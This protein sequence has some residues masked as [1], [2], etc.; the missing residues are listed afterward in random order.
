MLNTDI[1]GA[2]LVLQSPREP[3]L[4]LTLRRKTRTWPARG[5][6]STTSTTSLPPANRQHRIKRTKPSALLCH[7]T[8]KSCHVSTRTSFAGPGRATIPTPNIT[9]D[10]TL[11]HWYHGASIKQRYS[12]RCHLSTI[13]GLEQ[14]VFLLHLKSIG[15]FII[16]QS[17]R[18]SAEISTIE[19]DVWPGIRFM[20][21]KT[22]FR[23]ILHFGQHLDEKTGW[24]PAHLEL[25][26][27]P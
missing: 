21:C 25:M 1:Q 24:E 11:W 2:L 8:D 18:A 15:L 6:V 5:Y 10:S 20:H 19:R 22:A 12:L 13:E 7:G 17:S 14:V 9:F 16:Y 26:G 23:S 27:I 4:F 3:R